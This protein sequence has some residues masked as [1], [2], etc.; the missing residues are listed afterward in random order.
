MFY[1]VLGGF[2]RLVSRTVG[3]WSEQRSDML[4]SSIF[5]VM[6]FVRAI[7]RISGRPIVP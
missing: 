2:T 6:L 5:W 1:T 4:P 3:L 7:S